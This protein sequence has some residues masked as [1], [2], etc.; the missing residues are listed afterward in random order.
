LIESEE[1]D[2][3]QSQLVRQ[4]QPRSVALQSSLFVKNGGNE[5]D[6]IHNRDGIPSAL[7]VKRSSVDIVDEMPKNGERDSAIEQ[8]KAPSTNSKGPGPSNPQG[9]RGQSLLL[10]YHPKEI[11]EQMML[12][13]NQ[14]FRKI[15]RHEFLKKRFMKPEEAPAF[16]AMVTRFNLVCILLFTNWL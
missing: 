14:L 10:I 4:K 5:N 1:N 6:T 3:S 9:G 16:C 7:E 15:Q 13:E 8:D 11:A 2:V 12:L